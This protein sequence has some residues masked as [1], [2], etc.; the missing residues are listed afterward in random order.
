MRQR[1][2]CAGCRCSPAGRE[3][4][5]PL[6][7]RRDRNEIPPR[8]SLSSRLRGR[9]RTGEVSPVPRVRF[10]ERIGTLFREWIGHSTCSVELRPIRSGTPQ[11]NCR[12]EIGPLRAP[13]NGAKRQTWP[14]TPARHSG[15]TRSSHS[16]A[17]VGWA[18]CT[19]RGTRNS[20]VKSRSRSSAQ[21]LLG[22]QNG[23]PA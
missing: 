21:P 10:P 8:P 13:Y 14:S 12:G 20:I 4:R 1:P 15:R 6:G 5:V 19:S 2:P 9:T 18:R 17:R 3:V 7:R 22:T 16:S 11:P 23:S